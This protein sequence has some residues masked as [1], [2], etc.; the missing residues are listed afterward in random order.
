MGTKENKRG[1]LRRAGSG[2]AWVLFPVGAARS[3]RSQA[4]SSA[5]AVN[6]LCGTIASSVAKLAERHDDDE[7]IV[8][9]APAE[10]RAIVRNARTMW[11]V[12][13]GMVLAG[14]AVAVMSINL[15]AGRSIFLVV[16]GFVVSGGLSFVGAIMALDA[17]RVVAEMAD[18]RPID[19]LDFVRMPGRFIPW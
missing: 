19:W 1:F 10:A 8:L 18:Q 17:A 4:R 13:V 9:P 14:I 7:N 6:G 3:L 12:S 16:Q 11:I 2:I 15:F 5:R